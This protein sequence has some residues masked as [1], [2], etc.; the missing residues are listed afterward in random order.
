MGV[1]FVVL[2]IAGVFV[3]KINY[4]SRRENEIHYGEMN[5]TV[6]TSRVVVISPVLCVVLIAGGGLVAYFGWKKI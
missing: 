1:L 4:G 2:G 5:A 3:R 6:E